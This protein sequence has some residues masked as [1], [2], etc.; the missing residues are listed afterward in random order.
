MKFA[1]FFFRPCLH[2]ASL[3]HNRKM[4]LIAGDR[5]GHRSCRRRSPH[6]KRSRAARC[7][8]GGAIGLQHN[9]RRQAWR[10]SPF[11]LGAGLLLCRGAR[12]PDVALGSCLRCGDAPDHVDFR[13]P[14]IRSIDRT[15]GIAAPCNARLSQRSLPSPATPIPPY[16]VPFPLSARAQHTD[17][18]LL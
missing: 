3:R 15:R 11:R 2:R 13:H 8:L 16:G 4:R 7:R 5:C 10:G 9:R 18:L 6:R 1:P 14:Q 17:E 12:A